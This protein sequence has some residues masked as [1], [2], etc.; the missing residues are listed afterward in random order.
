MDKLRLLHT[1]S[2]R[3][4]RVYRLR[5]AHPLI[6]LEFPEKGVDKLPKRVYN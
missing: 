3:A 1:L 5:A 6:F 2:I 4:L